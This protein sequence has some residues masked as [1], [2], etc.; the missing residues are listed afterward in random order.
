MNSVT[1]AVV[2]VAAVA[3][4]ALLLGGCSQFDDEPLTPTAVTFQFSHHGE[5]VSGQ[6]SGTAGVDTSAMLT[7][8]GPGH[9]L[10]TAAMPKLVPQPARV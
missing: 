1:Q 3:A 10:L 6:W 2:P 7:S 9:Y 8:P 5:H 4:A